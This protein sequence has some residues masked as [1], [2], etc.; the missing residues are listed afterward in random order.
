MSSRYHTALS[1]FD[2]DKYKK[3]VEFLELIVDLF[4]KAYCHRQWWSFKASSV[5]YYFVYSVSAA[6][7]E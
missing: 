3:V 2:L 1:L 6:T 7:A 5:G 4:S